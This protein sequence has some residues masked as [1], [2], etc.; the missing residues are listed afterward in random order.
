MLPMCETEKLFKTLFVFIAN[1]DEID[2]KSKKCHWNEPKR[3]TKRKKIISTNKKKILP[4]FFVTV[5][6]LKFSIID[7]IGKSIGAPVRLRGCGVCILNNLFLFIQL[8][9][10]EIVWHLAV[11]SGKKFISFIFALFRRHGRNQFCWWGCLS[12]W[13]DSF[14]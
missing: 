10:S 14:R 9:L 1:S 6:S 5:G 8:V 11:F 3:K 12:E 7:H 2:K 13:I 4:F